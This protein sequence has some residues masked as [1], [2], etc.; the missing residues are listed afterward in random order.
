MEKKLKKPIVSFIV[1]TNL[2]FW[3]LFLLVGLTAMLELPKIVFDLILGISAWSS[4]FAFMILFRRIY[5]EQNFIAYVKS[6]FKERLQFSKVAVIVSIQVCIAVVVII[7]M[8]MKNDALSPSITISSLGMLVYYFIKTLVS[9]PFGEELGWRG[10]ALNELQKRYSALRSAVIIGFWW[11]MWHAPIWFTTGFTGAHLLQYIVFFMI[12]IIATTIIM[13][14][15]YNLNK[16]LWVP[17]IVHF[18]FNF[19]I[20]IRNGDILEFIM[21]YACLY[22]IVAIILILINPKK[23]LYGREQHKKQ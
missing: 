11:G 14:T 2:I 13:T 9:G 8:F 18:L 3:P 5:P 4:T 12:A 10:F 1:L 15:F 17:I 6:R 16:N 19:S 20:G 7:I 23:V 22:S 21:Y